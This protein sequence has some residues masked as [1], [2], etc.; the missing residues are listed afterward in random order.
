MIIQTMRMPRFALAALGLLALT[1]CSSPAAG[2]PQPSNSQSTGTS[3]S[4]SNSLASLAPCNLL[5]DANTSALHLIKKGPV[6]ISSKARSCDWGTDTNAVSD[7]HSIYSFS[8]NILDH[9]GVSDLNTNGHQ[10]STVD[11]N[12]RQSEQLYDGYGSCSVSM[13]VTSTSSVDIDLA[14]DESN[15]CT[16]ANGIAKLVEPNVP[17]G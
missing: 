3:S 6:N 1:A 17:K 9:E 11:I 15:A 14:A 7:P 8:V 4:A 5:S 12:G 2:Q 16:L 10:V 13:P